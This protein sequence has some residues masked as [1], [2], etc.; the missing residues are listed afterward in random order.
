EL[1]K[2]QNRIAEVGFEKW[3][4]EKIKHYSCL[5]CNTLNSAY[6]LIC[7]NCGMEP[8]CEYVRL[9]KKVIESSI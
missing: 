4:D 2:N 8:S 1:W 7:R 9:H 5:N 6:D 3:F